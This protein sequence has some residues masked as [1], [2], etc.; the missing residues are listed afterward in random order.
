MAVLEA[1]CAGL[2]GDSPEPTLLAS[3]IFACAR[4]LLAGEADGRTKY[5]LIGVGLSD[6]SDAAAADKGDMLDTETPKR[7]AAEAV[8]A[9]AEDAGLPA[10]DPVR[11]GAEALL[12]AVLEVSA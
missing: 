7:A 5:R 12:E 6:F 4:E 11:D 10:C 2:C 8:A 9:A 1:V 3:R